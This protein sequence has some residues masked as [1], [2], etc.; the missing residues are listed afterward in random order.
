[1]RKTIVTSEVIVLGRQGEDGANKV[2]FPVRGWKELYGDGQFV[3]TALRPDENDPYPVTTHIYEEDDPNVTRCGVFVEWIVGSADVEIPGRG[4]VELAYYTSDDVRVKSVVYHTVIY[5]S[6]GQNSLTPPEPWESWVDDVR[7]AGA[8]A[9]QAAED[10]AASAE[11]AAQSADDARDAADDA[12][13]YAES[14]A[15][16]VSTAFGQITA[17]ATTLSPG[18]SA[19]ASFNPS[20]KVMHFGIPKGDPGSGGGGDLFVAEFGIN[21]EHPTTLAE[22]R[23]AVAA[24]KV[25]YAKYDSAGYYAPLAF[26]NENGATFITYGP[27]RDLPLD[28]SEMCVMVCDSYNGWTIHILNVGDNAFVAVKDSTTFG[29]V[30]AAYNAGKTIFAKDATNNR[31]YVLVEYVHNNY[32]NRFTF[33]GAKGSWDWGPAIGELILEEGDGWT[34][35]G[36]TLLE[37]KGV[38]SVGN[39]EYEV[40]RKALAITENGVTTTY[41]VADIT[42]SL[43]H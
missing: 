11:G 15:T 3:V 34:A 38:I 42:T 21:V 39:Y 27:E 12:E 26:V 14:A 13:R 36:D 18:S 20:T 2:L 17:T 32:V 4:K 9:I 16:A 8:D 30:Y 33:T 25:V 24:G 10:A 23:A 40:Q 41:Y 28:Y 6:L 31:L 22:I 1:M 7:E 5:D 29:Q 19:T 37:K 35:G 43:V